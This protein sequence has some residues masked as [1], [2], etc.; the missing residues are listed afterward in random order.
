MSGRRIF[1]LAL[2]T[3]LVAPLLLACLVAA[4][5]AQGMPCCSGSSCAP[6]PGNRMCFW[7]AAPGSSYRSVPQDHCR[8]QA[9]SLSVVCAQM[10]LASAAIAKTAV[11]AAAASEESPPELYTLHLALLI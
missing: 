6:G 2:A 5:S 4:A 7:A 8:L 3:V 9:P 1:V 10:P 11:A